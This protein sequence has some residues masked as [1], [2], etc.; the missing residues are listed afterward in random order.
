MEVSRQ[1]ATRLDPCVDE[2][3]LAIGLE[4]VARAMDGVADLLGHRSSSTASVMDRV[5]RTR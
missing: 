3:V 1:A 4:G 2:E 5:S